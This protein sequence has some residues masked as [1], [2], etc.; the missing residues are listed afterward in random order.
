MRHRLRDHIRRARHV[1]VRGV[2]A[3]ADQRGGDRDGEGAIGIANLGHEGG[4]GPRA[5]GRVRSGDV[6]LELRQIEAQHALVVLFRA[7]F[8]LGVRLEQMLATVHERRQ[9]ATPGR[10]QIAQHALVRREQRRRGAELGAHVRDR[11]LARRAQ[12]SGARTDVLDD[13]VGGA[14]DAE[15]PGHVEDDVL[16]SGPAAEGAREMHSD[17]SG[18]EELPRQARDHLDR[19]GSPDTDRAAAEATGVRRVG[20]RPDEQLPGKRVVLEHHLM[21]DA[22][23][24]RPEPRAVARRSRAEKRVD[25]SVLAQR[26][27]EIGQTLA[28][29][30]DQVI[31]VDGRRH[32]D[33]IATGLHELQEAGLAEHVLE[34]DP[35]GAQRE[36]ALARRPGRRLRVVEVAEQQLVGERQRPADASA[37]D[38][39]VPRHGLVDAVDRGG[40]GCE[41]T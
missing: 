8:D 3:A 1:F 11:G 9:L 15:L 13:R 23:A 26:G 30:L 16:R 17:G 36:V 31:A 5:I 18:V 25:L 29:R 10:A 20:V 14:G 28:A 19:L 33:A 37:H 6:G 40:R 32:G 7:G 38:S 34:D 35:V 41:R 12:R 39:E 24:G 21:D 4:D 27:P 2:G 22:R